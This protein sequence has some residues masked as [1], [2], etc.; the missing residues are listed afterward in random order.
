MIGWP[1]EFWLAFKKNKTIRTQHTSFDFKSAT[2]SHCGKDITVAHT[3]LA[4]GTTLKPW[5]Q[6]SGL[7]GS[8]V[9]ITPQEKIRDS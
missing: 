7:A 6:A 2:G 4:S 8:K 9:G 5:C 3:H 1:H